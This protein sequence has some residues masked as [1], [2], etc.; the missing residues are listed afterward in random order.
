MNDLLAQHPA[1]VQPT[2]L[3]LAVGSLVV[4]YAIFTLVGFGSAL[5]A[6]APLALVM[7]VARIVPLLAMLDCGG[8]ALRGWQARQA[9]AWPEF[10]RL[11]P[12]MLL[13]QLL[14]VAVLA[15]LSPA[16]MAISLGLFVAI[17][18]LRGLLGKK[19][20][21]G[22]T[23]G[24]PFGYG[25]FGGVLGGLFGSGGFIYASYLERRL[26][27]RNAF[28]ATQAVLIALSTAWRIVLCLVAGLLD[29]DLLLQALACAPL[30][31]LGIYLGHHIDLRISREQL[32]LLLNGLLLAC[33]LS[34]IVRFAS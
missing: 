4:A 10:R 16:L 24:H 29:L 3:L 1:S 21:P 12:G 13:G 14:G 34:L 9:V 22:A 19:T 6:G 15:R 17:Q 32:F 27:E 5:L 23:T 20:A 18:G 26:A 8:A 31:G 33:G 30:M 2:H 11:F 28:R 25:I 7:P